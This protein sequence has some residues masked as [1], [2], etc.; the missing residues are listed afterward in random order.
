MYGNVRVCLLES[1]YSQARHLLFI[2]LSPLFRF[3]KL[4]PLSPGF[5]GVHGNYKGVGSVKPDMIERLLLTGHG[6]GSAQRRNL[7]LFA[8][9]LSTVA[10]SSQLRRATISLEHATMRTLP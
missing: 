1:T 4:T 2:P 10:A 5:C 8:A 7:H 9:S 3:I 6:S